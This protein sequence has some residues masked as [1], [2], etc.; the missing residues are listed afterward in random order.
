[1]YED[2]K[3]DGKYHWKNNILKVS[4]SVFTP[5]ICSKNFEFVVKKIFNGGF[6]MNKGGQELEI[7][8][9]KGKNQV[10]LEK[11]SIKET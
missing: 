5:T 2:K 4:I 9:F 3:I 8:A 11:S 6:E 10:Y 7:Y 1:V